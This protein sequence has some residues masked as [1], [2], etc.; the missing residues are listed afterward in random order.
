MK[1]GVQGVVVLYFI[2]P[3]LC[4]VSACS[5]TDSGVQEHGPQLRIVSI[6]SAEVTSNGLTL[7]VD[8][9]EGSPFA[10]VSESALE[11]NIT[12]TATVQNP[13]PACLDSLDVTLDKALGDRTIIDLSSNSKVPVLSL[14]N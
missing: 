8:S 4:M 13:G 11:V 14:S 7:I 10:K 5:R 3:L 1:K 6:D 2:L 9:C 12:V